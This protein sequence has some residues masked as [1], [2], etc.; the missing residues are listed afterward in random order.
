MGTLTPSGEKITSPKGAYDTIVAAVHQVELIKTDA[1]A[2]LTG[3]D[4]KDLVIAIVDQFVSIPM[5]PQWLMN[6]LLS[7][8]IDLLIAFLNKK[9]GP[10][11]VTKIV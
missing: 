3:T 8:G 2:A 1:G 7:Y 9:F 6:D 11:W 5:V 10:D 4:K